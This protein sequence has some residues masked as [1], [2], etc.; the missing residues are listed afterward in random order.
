[1]NPA[2]LLREPVSQADQK[3]T[4]PGMRC[5]FD[6]HKRNSRGVMAAE[7][8]RGA[9]NLSGGQIRLLD[10]ADIPAKRRGD[11]FPG[12]HPGAENH[13]LG[14]G[15][16]EHGGLDANGTTAPIEYGVDAAAEGMLHGGCAGG[17][18]RRAAI[19][20]GGG[21]GDLGLAEQGNRRGM[22][23]NT[24][25]DCRSSRQRPSRQLRGGGNHDGQRSGPKDAAGLLRRIRPV[26]SPEPRILQTGTMDNQRVVSRTSLGREDAL[27]RFVVTSIPAEAIDGFR[28]KG[29]KPAAGEDFRRVG[30]GR[31]AFLRPRCVK[32]EC[33]FHMLHCVLNRFLLVLR[34]RALMIESRRAKAIPETGRAD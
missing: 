15:Q 14:A 13:W 21:D 26:G 11:F 9:Q 20:A 18:E 32:D 4:G 28:R 24:K 7:L 34:R 31:F 25:A 2:L 1:M 6:E 5:L 23:R 10:K 29:D 3:I 33:F 30:D 8:A 19:G 16:I 22:G 17:R 12:D 27:D